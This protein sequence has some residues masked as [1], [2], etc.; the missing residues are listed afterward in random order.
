[1]NLVAKYLTASVTFVFAFFS[2]AK[3]Q[4]FS[5]RGTDFWVA[6]GY[7]QVMTGAN[8]QEMVLYFAAEQAATV[9]VTIPG[10]GY[11]QTYNLAAN[12]V[13]TSA[14]IPSAGAQDA[15]LLTETG[16]P[17]NKG[18]HITSTQPIVCYAHIYNQSVSGATILFPTNTLGREYYSINFQNNSNTANANCW[19]YVIATD[20]G[21]TTIEVT[22]S[23]A[24]LTKPAGVPFTVNLTQ[25]QVFNLMGQTVGT[26]GVDLTGTFIRS[27]N[28]GNGCKKI[29]VFS[30]SGRINIACGVGPTTTSSDNYMVQAFPKNAWGKRFLTA[31]AAG[32]QTFNFYRVC[33]SD[34]TTNV[35]LNGAPIGLPLQS[36]FYYQIGP[37]NQPLRIDADKP[38]TV[39][40]Y[41]T[42]QDRCGNGNPGDPEVI[43]LSPVEQNI[44]RVLFNSNLLVAANPQHFVN[45]VIPNGGTAI[46]SFRLDGAVPGTP[47]IVH[48]R[49]P[50]YS[51][52]KI[53]GLALG[54]HLMQSDSGFNA[55]AY[56]FAN[57]ESYGYNAGTNVIDLYQF[58]TTQNANAVVNAPVA[59]KSSPFLMAVTLP[60]L[61]LSMLWEISGFPNV[62]VSNPVPDSTY[63]LNGRTLNVFRLPSQYT[64]N[65]IGTY[66][67]KVTVNTPAL[68]DGCPGIQV[69]N[70]SLQV[71]NQPTPSFTINS[72]G[73]VDSAIAFTTNNNGQGRPVIKH[74]WDFGDNT[75][76]STN[77]PIKTFLNPG[78]YNV[79]YAIMTDAGCLSDTLPFVVS[80]TNTPTAKF[81][82]TNPQ[83]IGNSITF[84][85]TSKLTGN[86]GNIVNWNWNLGNSTILNNPNG[87]NVTTTYPNAIPYT[88]T[89]QV[90]TNT[91]CLSNVYQLPVNVNNKPI[92][93]FTNL[94][95]CL[96]DGVVNFSDAS[97]IADGTQ[98]QF[99]YSW[100][101]G[102]TPSGPLN[103]SNI[104]NP[105]HKYPSVGPFSVKLIVTSNKGCIDSVTK[106][107]AN[108]YPQPKTGFTAPAEVCYQTP[109]TFND[110]TNG[111]T[112]P[113]TR[114]E[115]R[116]KNAS[117][118]VIGSSTVKDPVYNFPAPGTYFV[119]HWAF[120][121]QNCV[122]DTVEKP[123]VINPW[124][125]TDFSTS[126]I[127]C[128]KNVITFSNNSN[129]QAGTLVRW[130]WNLGDG[131]IINA[132]NGNAF[133]HTYAAWGNKTIKLLVESSKGCRSDT[134]IR[135]ILVNPLPRP[136]FSNV[137]G[138]LPDGVVN[139]TDTSKIP[140]AT[141]NLFTY[142]W[143]FGDVP[144][145]ALN[146]STVK[147]PSHRYP[148]VGPFTVKL[149][150]TSN[151][152]CIDS[153]Q[154]SIA[155]IYPQPKTNFNAPAEVCYQTPVTFNDNTNGITHPV[156]RWEWRFKNASGTI[157]GSS[158]VKDPVY[159]FP[160][161]GTYFVQH[162]AFT[163]Q[164]CVSD[165]IEKQIII[166]PWPTASFSLS[167]PA[168][169]RN[170]VQLNSTSVPNAGSLVRWYWSLGDG[171]IVNATNNNPVVHTYAN[172]G[173]KSI[174]LLVE[175]S[176][177]CRSDTL[178]Q[179][180]L[181]NPVPK[182]GYILPEVC[183]TDGVATFIDTSKIADGSTAQLKYLWSFNTG[184]PA[185]VPAPSPLTSTQKSPTINFFVAQNYQLN[186]RVES[187]DGCVDSATNV[188]YTINGVIAKAD[189][190]IIANGLCSNQDIK[191]QNKSSVVFGWLTKAEIYWDW[192]NNPTQVEVDDEPAVDEIYSHRY[193]NFQTPLTRTY[194]VRLRVFSGVICEKDVIYD[195]VV[196]AS[197][198]VTF[199]PMPGICVDAAP[200]QIT[201]AV[202]TGGLP[203][204][205]AVYSGPGV[206]ATGLFDPAAAGVGI[207]TI[208]Y[209]FTAQNGCTHYSENQIEVWPRPTA[210]LNVLLP[211]CEK[212]AITFNSNG[213]QHNAASLSTWNWN[214][215]DN[216]P[217]VTTSSN[218]PVTHTY[219][220]YGNYT[221]NLVVTNN[222]GCNSL[223]EPLP[224]RV[225]PLPVVKFEIP[226]ICLPDGTGQ[227]KDVS[228]IPDNTQSSFK[229]RWDFG[230]N[231]AL[232]VNSDTSIV[233]DPVYKYKNLGP[234]T[235]QLKV[236]SSNN[237]I[238]SSSLQLVDV[239]PQP[240]AKFRT[241]K[242]SICIGDLIDFT[243]E[244]DALVR[245][246]TRWKWS[247]GNGDSS[248]VENPRYRFPT[249]S[250]NP[251]TV[252]LFVY[253]EEGCISDTATKPINVWS[254]PVISAGPDFTMLQDGVRKI[255]D[256][257]GTGNNVQFLWTPPTYLD[258]VTLSNPTIIK[259]QDDIT[260]KLTVTGRG[261]CIMTDEVFVKVLKAP[262]PPNTFTPNGDGIN[263]QWEIKYLN[264][265]PGCI[266][267][268]YNTAGTLVYRTVGYTTPWNGIYNG[269][270]L[271]AGTY[272]YVIDPKNGRSRIAGYVTIL[273]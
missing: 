92:P 1:M 217:I 69:I 128:E 257:R 242:D 251:Y 23:A 132:N 234:Y 3:S 139:F 32:N 143:N 62:S 252:K 216:T 38:I 67:I 110:Q 33:V 214:F 30:G 247:F 6:Y 188:P 232:P 11:S 14:A 35:Q 259:P 183:L 245:N 4:D 213:S 153:T 157:I 146:T 31:T 171:T 52:I 164:N 113:V 115:W 53:P 26:T 223:P 45:I 189:Y 76:A 86:Y 182:V 255:I 237:C 99:S 179:S 138:C 85:D 151:N 57:A 7:H 27:I 208:R 167:T 184:T 260:Y 24:T 163:N 112:H 211:N 107:V 18:I 140:D 15:R 235:V 91:G 81:G 84:G 168:C 191:I 175:S 263:D 270:P 160:A 43:Y 149:I 197:P 116:F 95:A 123:I 70:W 204:L 244:S 87:N 39:A 202:E 147:N 126:P 135:P 101:F 166:N 162:W 144:S 254:Y 241:S 225:N 172:W 194:K 181:I 58:I 82:F 118:T 224:I 54:Q 233:K 63:V 269:Q 94:F 72:K 173:N 125:T 89:L 51:Y 61:P 134:T 13:L 220:A 226:K 55:I 207:H 16:S 37:T 60:Y 264:D 74:Y 137:H 103:F 25:G 47:F 127:L 64:Y 79:R 199:A 9:T 83:C 34:P 90:R 272:Y 133:T 111:I 230:D 227:F 71:F 156:T 48:P 246:V 145:G 80:V 124:P 77:N 136:G 165:T 154:K 262:K 97:T 212:N 258:N 119:Q 238:D 239:F 105:S 117:G 17:E 178:R 203:L 206:N 196:N 44:N 75:F 114:W 201:Q 19:A 98:N 148:S 78:Q 190:G 180:I 221:A 104:K 176:K 268:V 250:T 108:I 130:Y 10:N 236:L 68:Q 40:Q 88:A 249:A 253:S 273:R 59:C 29:A 12:S 271:P 155:N 248:F 122:S 186:L 219:A 65:T 50:N 256:A 261:G 36:N 41:F 5:N 187:K 2:G 22:P 185:I 170:D 73:C 120:T 243:D 240:K 205:S 222:R 96:P 102:N 198:L 229:Y 20:T 100:N 109:V 267:E 93:D 215:G 200:R 142:Q 150:V 161:P 209:T 266:I 193:P 121:N 42:S 195:V 66:P 231:S 192:E 28:S 46:S 169:E 177:G 265:Y 210:K 49:D 56:G 106:S 152:G 174:K 158:T 218:A 228:T 159:N 21:T 8:S 131:T 141:Q 129:P